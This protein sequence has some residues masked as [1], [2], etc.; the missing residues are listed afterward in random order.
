MKEA[1]TVH[2]EKTWEERLAELPPFRQI[3]G[4]LPVPVAVYLVKG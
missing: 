4:C 2:I 3:A 1:I